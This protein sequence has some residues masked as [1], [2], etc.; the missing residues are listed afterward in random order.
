MAITPPVIQ[1]SA[2]RAFFRH[3]A[4]AAVLGFIGGEIWWRGYV[5]PRKA[6]RDEYYRSQGVTIVHPFED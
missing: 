3:V 4:I 1:G 5:L 6:R 2:R